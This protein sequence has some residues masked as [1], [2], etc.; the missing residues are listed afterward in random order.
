MPGC[1]VTVQRLLRACP[2]APCAPSH[3]TSMGHLRSW[4]LCH[5]GSKKSPHNAEFR[6]S[7]WTLRRIVSELQLRKMRS[8][9]HFGRPGYVH[10][11]Y[12][13]SWDVL[14]PRRVSPG[15]GCW[16]HGSWGC[17]ME[18][19]GHLPGQRWSSGRGQGPVPG[20][21]SSSQVHMSWTISGL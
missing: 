5:C 12:R 8:C 9:V 11:A 7:V 15:G 17:S 1:A 21:T 14:P 16:E 19:H 13:P 18:A 2:A 20:L 4:V 3:S 6:Q 10:T